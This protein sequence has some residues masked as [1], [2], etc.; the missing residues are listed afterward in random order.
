MGGAMFGLTAAVVQM[1]IRSLIVRRDN[2]NRRDGSRR[3]DKER[4]LISQRKGEVK[5]RK[6]VKPFK[7]ILNHHS[8]LVVDEDGGV[9]THVFTYPYVIPV[10]YNYGKYDLNSLNRDYF[11]T[12]TSTS[13]TTE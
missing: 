1:L 4:R 10:Y 12:T 8:P 2:L 7:T 9:I 5:N 3:M 13:T 11:K 6:S